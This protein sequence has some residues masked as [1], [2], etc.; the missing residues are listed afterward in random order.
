[1]PG[2]DRIIELIPTMEDEKLFNV[3]ENSANKLSEGP[4]V[5]AD[6]VLAAVEREWKKRLDLARAGKYST[7]R[8]KI[9]MLKTL[10]YQVGH[11][12]GETP[13]IRRQILKHVLERQLPMVGS[14]T[15]TDEWVAPNSSMRYRKLIRFLESELNSERNDK[16]PNMETAMIE[17]GEDLEWVQKNYAHLAT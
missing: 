14:P 8:P 10:G 9:G 15:Y 11:V 7:A 5:E 4:N 6:S 3:F 13:R 16:R 17:W 12:Q 1:M 2:V